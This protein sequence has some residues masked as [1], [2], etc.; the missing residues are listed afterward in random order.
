MENTNYIYSKEDVLNICQSIFN[1]IDKC[2]TKLVKSRLNSDAKMEMDASREME[3]LICGI[4]QDI[5]VIND[6]I[7]KIDE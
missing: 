3:S 5:T 4:Q 2:I 7:K 1:D 6:Y